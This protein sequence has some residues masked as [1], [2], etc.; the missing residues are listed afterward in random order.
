[1]TITYQSSTS[2]LIT[3]QLPSGKRHTYPSFRL[4]LQTT[5]LHRSIS[6]T[7]TPMGI[8]FRK[9]RYHIRYQRR[10]TNQRNRLCSFRFLGEKVG[11]ANWL[12]ERRLG[13]SFLSMSHL[14]NI[15]TV[16]GSHCGIKLWLLNLWSHEI[17]LFIWYRFNGWRN[18]A[19]R[20]NLS[21]WSA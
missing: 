5:N 19:R 13:C 21:R 17:L 12:F 4:G 6:H 1:M 7:L 2:Y 8:H 9:T 3:V 10:S 16:D 18:N 11:K 15:V 20:P 14:W